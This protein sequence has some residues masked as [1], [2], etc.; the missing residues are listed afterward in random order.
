MG[1]HRHRTRNTKS[2]EDRKQPQA[3]VSSWKIILFSI[4]VP[5]MIPIIQSEGLGAGGEGD[6][7][8]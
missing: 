6:D 2:S 5:T 8:G 1:L 7:R 4:I 3:P